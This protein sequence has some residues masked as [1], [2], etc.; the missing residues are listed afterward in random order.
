MLYGSLDNDNRYVV[1]RRFDLLLGH[2]GKKMKKDLKDRKFDNPE[3]GESLK[4]GEF[5]KDGFNNKKTG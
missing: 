2:Q 5:Y 1:N 3:N 4:S